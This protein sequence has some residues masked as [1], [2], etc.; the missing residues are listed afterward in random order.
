[1]LTHDDLKRLA[2]VCG[3]CLTIFEPLRDEYSQVTKPAT[4]VVAAIQEAGRLLEEK[5]FNAADRDEMLQPL[6]K[7]AANT[8]WSARK[9]SLVMFRAPGF[10]MTAFWPDPLAHRVHFAQEFLILPLLEGM[11]NGHDFWLLALTLKAVRLFRGSR[12]G[13]VEIALPRGVPRNVAEAEGFDQPDHSL[14]GRSTAGPSVGNMKG[15]QFGTSNEKESKSDHLYDFFK[16]IDR[17]IRPL[18]EAEHLPLILAGVTR[19]LAIYRK[20]NTYSPLLAGAIHG[21]PYDGGADTLYKSAAELISAYA[22]REMDVTLNK[23]D[24]S[25]NRGLAATE[26]S[27]VIEAA[28][29]GEVDLLMIAPHAPGYAQ[30]EEAIN[31]AALATIRNGGKFGVLHGP[32]PESGMAAILRFH[33]PEKEAAAEPALEAVR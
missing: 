22:A 9:G 32:R 11:G 4:R 33:S 31:W 7:L 28:R 3:S 14:R 30:R 16:A 24:E 1:M 25:A 21:S 29:A 13:L 5:G 18:L 10:T 6:H 8:D 23:L 19:E 17:G 27:A 15:V 20:A 12:A 2:G 26:P